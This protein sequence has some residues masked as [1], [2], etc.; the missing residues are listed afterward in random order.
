MEIYLAVRAQK[1]SDAK[2]AL[3]AANVDV[4]NSNVD[5]IKPAI[6]NLAEGLHHRGVVY[7]IAGCGL[8][9]LLV[10]GGDDIGR[11]CGF[12]AVEC[13]F[14]AEWYEVQA[15]KVRYLRGIAYCDAT[16]EW[17]DQFSVADQTRVID[18]QFLNA[19]VIPASM[20]LPTLAQAERVEEQTMEPKVPQIKAAKVKSSKVKA[21]GTKVDRT[22]ANVLRESLSLDF[23]T[24]GGGGVRLVRPSKKVR[25]IFKK[26][27][28]IKE[29]QLDI[30]KCVGSNLS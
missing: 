6:R 25:P 29:E 2:N 11:F 18:V 24:A 15:A 3:A 10:E 19:D 16:A 17:A 14:A 20:V 13:V 9:W 30:F 7:D 4:L 28:K 1:L 22:G 27:D 23:D 26:R 21:S 5:R 12:S 8:F